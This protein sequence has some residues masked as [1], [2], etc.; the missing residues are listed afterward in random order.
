MPGSPPRSPLHGFTDEDL[1]EGWDLLQTLGQLRVDTLA[2]SVDTGAVQAL[3]D[4]ENL[5]F[6]IADAALA[7][8]FPVVHQG[9]FLNLTQTQG[10]EVTLSVQIFVDRIDAM[11]SGT[12][13]HGREGVEAARWLAK[14]G[15]T[16]ETRQHARICS[17]S[18]A[19]GQAPRYRFPLTRR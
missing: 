17:R 6:P 11:A 4:W 2:P 8:R 3:D 13:A 12:S 14:R 5:W 1:R 10:P 9:L 16:P 15:L 19:R 7:R 18:S